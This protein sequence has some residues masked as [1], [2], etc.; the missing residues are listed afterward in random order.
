MDDVNFL[1]LF[2]RDVGMLDILLGGLDDTLYQEQ[3]LLLLGLWLGR[4]LHRRSRWLEFL[5]WHTHLRSERSCAGRLHISWHEGLGW[6][7]CRCIDAEANLAACFGLEG[8]GLSSSYSGGCE[9]LELVASYFHHTIYR[10]L[11]LAC[12]E[13][14]SWYI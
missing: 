8:V 14:R 12:R 9:W 6:R 4:W 3:G 13:V 10:I 1:L 2:G 11:S 5:G 7:K